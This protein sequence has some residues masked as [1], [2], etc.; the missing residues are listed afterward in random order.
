MDAKPAETS[1]KRYRYHFANVEFD[2]AKFELSRAGLVIPLEPK[3]LD[4]LVYFLRNPDRVISTEEFLDRVWAVE[5][6]VP[7]VLTN[8][9][10]NLRVAI[11]D[12]EK[13]LI[14]TVFGVGYRFTASIEL[15]EIGGAGYEIAPLDVG[16]PVPWRGNFSLT[17]ELGQTEA[18][19]TWLAEQTGG[20]EKRV[21]RFCRDDRGVGQLKAIASVAQRLREALGQ[22]DDIV[23]IFEWDFEHVPNFL[24]Y[25]HAGEDI[26]T[27]SASHRELKRM[28]LEERLSFFLQIAEPVAAGHAVAI[29][30]NNLKPANILVERNPAGGWRVRLMDFR[31]GSGLTT[32][33]PDMSDDETV[34]PDGE[35]DR[36]V[37]GG[38]T[39]TVADDIYDLGLI[40]YRTVM[41][42]FAA[43]LTSDW[44]SKVMDEDLRE[45]IADAT[46]GDPGKGLRSVADLIVRLRS[47]PERRAEREE[48]RKR[49]E[50][51][52]RTAE[53]H[54]KLMA[55]LP[56]G[57]AAI[58]FLL[59]GLA[60]SL[61]LYTRAR[62]SEEL[63]RQQLST[64]QAL[65][66][67]LTDDMIGAAD[68]TVTGKSNMTV[69]EA[70]RTAAKRIDSAFKDQPPELRANLHLEM[71]K[72]YIGLT[73]Y[74]AARPEAQRAL[75]ILQSLPGAAP[76]L[77]ADAELTMA[78]ILAQL[79]NLNEALPHIDRAA[80]L[81][82]SPLLAGSDLQVRLLYEQADREISALE[83]PDAVRHLEQAWRLAQ[84]L[85][86]VPI[87]GRD[88][89]EHTLADAYRLSGDYPKAKAAF[90]DLITRQ[91]I[92]YGGTD[93][94]TLKNVLGLSVVYQYEQN[95]DSAL[96]LLSVVIPQIEKNVG[97]DNDDWLD[98]RT[99]LAGIYFSAEK[100]DDA[101]AIWT[102]LAERAA[103]K[104]GEASLE[105]LAKEVNIATSL[106]LSHKPDQAE[107]ILRKALALARTA[108]QPDAAEIQNLRYEL[109]VAILDQ[110][111]TAEVADLLNGLDP[112]KINDAHT[113][114]DWDGRLAFQAGRLALLMG[115]KPKA[116]QL[117]T[118]AKKII[119]EKNPGGLI[120]DE[121][122][123]RL[124]D[125]AS[126]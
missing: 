7:Q 94:R 62:A 90:T 31:G 111:H 59:V 43:R 103:A 32:R 53:A 24:E 2:E 81:L 112:A 118:A 44:Q 95:Y 83:F 77:S 125:Q 67:F 102:D 70:A 50:H 109:A 84:T 123:D 82:K 65:V 42:D 39:R 34:E 101:I 100:Y 16:L 12:H 20:G 17:K 37:V 48:A 49:T 21:Y 99:E 36:Q 23:R 73:D 38:A 41:A 58:A 30:H 98:A 8:Q 9:V 87:L 105:F 117:L 107:A 29:P 72:T 6:V 1:G 4:V 55:L 92:H 28:S 89:I 69:A 66:A 116:L 63:Y 22:R 119:D 79:S 13:V 113:E 75:D 19:S 33:R 74:Q 3:A 64:T 91:K 11:G 26:Q 121:T 10:R 61:Y 78:D 40:L 57:A 18:V 126:H 86:S 122:I 115:D 27:W 56:G 85:P 71:A 47:L 25:E 88:E 114:P 80:Q 96:Q 45:D 35:H 110:H 60:V 97:T 5:S 51:E 14:K 120:A 93:E 124:I 52:R 108:F 68:P 104:N 15:A 76:G 54:R 46:N 106:R